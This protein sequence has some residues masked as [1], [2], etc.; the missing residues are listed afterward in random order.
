MFVQNRR[1]IFRIMSK[2]TE[3]KY[4]HLSFFKRLKNNFFVQVLLALFG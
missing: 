1:G 4:V 2:E 3:K